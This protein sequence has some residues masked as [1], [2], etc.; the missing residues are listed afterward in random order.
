V[1]QVGCAV[2]RATVV[3]AGAASALATGKR[4]YVVTGLYSAT[5]TVAAVNVAFVVLEAKTGLDMD[6]PWGYSL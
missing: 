6:K 1:W 2:A 3:A 5:S 4:G